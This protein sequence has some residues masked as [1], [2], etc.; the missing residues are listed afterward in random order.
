LFWLNGSFMSPDGLSQASDGFGSNLEVLEIWKG[1][2]LFVAATSFGFR[3]EDHESKRQT[4]LV[5]CGSGDGN[6][7]LWHASFRRR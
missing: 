4:D 5:G 1:A 6:R 3:M 7:H 2:F